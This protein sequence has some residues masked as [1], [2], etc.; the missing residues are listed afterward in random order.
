MP[1]ISLRSLPWIP[2]LLGTSLLLHVFTL[3][4]LFDVRT[5]TNS[6]FATV[7]AMLNTHSETLETHDEEIDKNYVQNYNDNFA[8][9]QDINDLY[10]DA[11]EAWVS[12]YSIPHGDTRVSFSYLEPSEVISNLGDTDPEFVANY[13]DAYSVFYVLDIEDTVMPDIGFEDTQG[14]CDYFAPGSEAMTYGSNIFCG[15]IKDEVAH[16]AL[17][18]K[19]TFTMY[20]NGSTYTFSFTA[21]SGSTCRDEEELTPA[22]EEKYFAPMDDVMS[23]MLSSFTTGAL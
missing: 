4:Y 19:A 17:Q 20:Q 8:V 23:A 22:C 21:R 11:G 9:R 1:K 10:A 18:R 16:N 7:S 6:S 3:G 13:Q 12:P 15:S 14:M 5:R 2:L